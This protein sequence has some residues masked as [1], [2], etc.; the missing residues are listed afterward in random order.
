[1]LTGVVEDAVVVAEKVAAG[2]NGPGDANILGVVENI[3][4]GAY[5]YPL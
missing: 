3:D 2:P 4:G 1:M 5:R